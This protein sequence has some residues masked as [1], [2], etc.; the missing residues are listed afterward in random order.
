[1][2]RKN[3]ILHVVFG[4]I[5]ANLCISAFFF[6]SEKVPTALI[7]SPGHFE[8]G[9][10]VEIQSREKF[11]LGVTRVEREIA[12]PMAYIFQIL[13]LLFLISPPLMVLLLFCIWQ[14]LKEKNRMK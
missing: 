6:Y 3:R 7:D 9:L 8:R 2:E 4:F 12:S 1:M 13:F 5:V 14:E 11:E 10:P